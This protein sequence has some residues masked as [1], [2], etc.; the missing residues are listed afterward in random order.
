VGDPECDCEGGVSQD[1]ICVLVLVGCLNMSFGWSR[2]FEVR[3][4]SGL[5]SESKSIEF[6]ER[7]SPGFKIGRIGRE[8]GS[9]KFFD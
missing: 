9:K 7:E 5:V 4:R 3:T 1:L 2:S 6:A 8:G